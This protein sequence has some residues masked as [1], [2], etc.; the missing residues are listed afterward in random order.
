MS[1]GSRETLEKALKGLHGD[2]LVAWFQPAQEVIDACNGLFLGTRVY[3]ATTPSPHWHYVSFGLT[4]LR[5][6][7]GDDEPET[8][9]EARTSGFGFELSC[10]IPWV[11]ERRGFFRR[12]TPPDAAPIWP[13]AVFEY[14]ASYSGD[15]IC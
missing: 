14:L 1:L 3:R 11:P 13:S 12:A 5:G 2:A 6:V 4:D 8:P 15:H 10:R 7:G 9:P